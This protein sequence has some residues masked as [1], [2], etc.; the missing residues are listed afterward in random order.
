[1]SPLLAGAVPCLVVCHVGCVVPFPSLSRLPGGCPS[2]PLLC[3]YSLHIIAVIGG[4]VA[5]VGVTLFL[6]VSSL[7]LRIPLRSMLRIPLPLSIYRS[8]L[9]LTHP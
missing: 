5:V 9:L 1:M 8:R 6:I 7:S 3:W 2:A 4:G